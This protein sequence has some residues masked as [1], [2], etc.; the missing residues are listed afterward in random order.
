MALLDPISCQIINTLQTGFPL[1]QRPFLEA[2]Q[3]L[4]I[5]K[6]VLIEKI[7]SLLNEGY[8]TRFGPLF[9]AEQM[10]GG[11]TLAALSVPAD[12]FD[13]VT[14]LV[15]RF[16]EVA[17]NYA[18]E[19]T[20]NMW[21]VLATE[22]KAEIGEV[23]G[24]IEAATGLTVF[25]LPK[26]EEYRLGFKLSISPN[27]EI[28]TARLEGSESF[29]G[30]K[31]TLQPNQKDRA[32]VEATQAGL[33]LVPA[34]YDQI[35]KQLEVEPAEVIS[36]F[37]MM[38]KQGWVRRLG[39]VPNHIK[40]GL[41][42]NGMS[43]WSLPEEK[44]VEQGKRVGA[45]SFV[46]HCYRRPTNLPHWPYNMFVMVH[47]Q[48]RTIVSERVEAISQLLGEDDSDH[49]ILYSSRILKKTGLRIK[50]E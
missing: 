15:N 16:P 9:N 12:R 19:H 32:L 47:G 28:D 41:R 31:N 36:R 23:I 20:L 26:L 11:L 42:S 30:K 5:T 4:Q 17:H 13:Q 46:S 27:G 49:K 10:G 24:K 25:N 14:E 6:T 35:A 34:P 48:D 44:I 1:C 8:L 37:E 2:A 45:L 7:Q 22:T 50:R 40:L 38:I 3:R 21:F 18:R 39:L 33:P 43:V 29:F